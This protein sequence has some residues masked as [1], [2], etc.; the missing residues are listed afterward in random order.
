MTAYY[1]NRE[2]GNIQSHPVSGLGDDF[3]SDEVGEDGKVVKPFVKLPI[4]DDKIKSAKSLMKD[5]DSGSKPGTGSSK[6]E[7]D[8]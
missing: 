3:N 8:Q 6:Q 4:T 1:R 5:H 7:G 2:T